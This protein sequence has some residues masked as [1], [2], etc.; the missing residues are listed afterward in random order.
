MIKLSD[1]MAEAGD[2]ADL[3][4]LGHLAQVELQHRQAIAVLEATAIEKQQEIRNRAAPRRKTLIPFSGFGKKADA[5]DQYAETEL[6]AIRL[7]IAEE[8]KHTVD[9]E[10]QVHRLLH[11]WLLL[12]DAEYQKSAEIEKRFSEI[13]ADIE[14]L[15]GALVDLLSRYGS[16][17]NEIAVSYDKDAQMLSTVSLAA[18]DRL[19][20]SY[21]LLLEEQNKFGYKIECLNAL[22]DTPLYRDMKLSQFN[23]LLP[24]DCRRGMDYTTLRANFEQGAAKVKEAIRLLQDYI[25]RIDTLPGEMSNVLFEY[26]DAL[27]H[28]YIA[29]LESGDDSGPDPELH[30]ITPG[31]PAGPGAPDTPKAA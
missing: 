20:Y 29:D 10:H 1:M 17:R 28:R 5:P 26:R 13:H 22:V 27:W 6:E 14:P 31:A 8:R 30:L 2:H 7:R 19:V 16:T 3:E 9:C 12:N 23:Q 15:V 18:L 21:E 4:T 24:P 25:G 11:T